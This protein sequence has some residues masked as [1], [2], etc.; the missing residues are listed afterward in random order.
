M[1]KLC[2]V[3]FLCYN[4][5]MKILSPVGNFESLKAAVFNGAD[6]VYLGI[7]E[8][9]A[10]NNIDGFSLEDLKEVVDFSHVFDVKVLLAIN[11][12]FS[13]EELQSALDTVVEAYNFGVDAFI[14]QDLGLA[15]LISENFP[16]I[17]L[18][19]STQLALHNL[20]GVKA[21]EKF[22]FKRV[23]LARET[24]LEEIKRIKENSDVEIEYFAQG[25][26][27]V[28]FSGNCY[29]SSHL[30]NASGN[31]GR[32]KQLC[33]LPY[34]LEKDGR[35]LKKGYLLS[36]KDLNMT[37]RLND[38]KNAGV[39]VLKIEG[40]ARR[41]SYVAMA[42]REYFNALHGKKAS[43]E[44]LKLAF[45]RNFTAG[46]FD[47]NGDIISNFHN[48]IGVFVGKI[49]KVVTG[50]KF[51]EVFFSSNRKLSP[52]STFKTFVNGAEKTTFTAFDLKEISRGGYRATTTQTL[53]IGDHVHLIVDAKKEEEALAVSKR[54]IVQIKIFAVENL[55][56]KAQVCLPCK[57][58]EIEGDVCQIAQKQPLSKDDFVLSFGKSDLFEA[59]LE[60]VDFGKVFMTKKQLNSFRRKVFDAIFEE[61]TSSYRHNLKKI[62]VKNDYRVKRFENFQI[63]ENLSEKLSAENIVYSPS[64]YEIE[65]VKKF[66]SLCKSQNKKAF[67]DLPNFALKKD[68]AHLKNLVKKTNITIIANNCF[69]LDFDAEM[70]IGAGM[71][72]YNSVTASIFDKPILTA[73]SDI[74]TR[75]DFPYMTLRHCPFKCH[76]G[77]S[78]ANCPYEDGFTYRMDNGKVLKLKRK[79]L[80]TCTFYLTD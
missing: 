36:A 74:S 42:T 73:E 12:L 39:S 14:V 26:L 57:T 37:D 13:D 56:V 24:P 31:R 28:S 29:L 44:N 53:C 20:E 8:F 48:H 68:V 54:R 40:R 77:A 18:H 4:K 11:I 47:G 65:D 64:F 21:V 3:V 25:A 2:C 67:L 32:C 41:A 63:V 75:I 52:Q 38:L 69:A 70:V 22:G 76:F 61:L 66:Q 16:Q 58:L 1:Q 27:C 45:N 17:E 60:F 50:K 43:V 6:E 80:S 55:P 7:N 23:V 19:A 59:V 30:C 35:V 46:Y 10:R 9:N 51:N 79:K 62:S 15:K 78:C 71:N 5:D 34:S 33:R 72:V 49:E